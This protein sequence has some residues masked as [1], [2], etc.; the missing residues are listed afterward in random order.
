MDVS[1]DPT[2]NRRYTYGL[3]RWLSP[4]PLAGEVAKP[5]SLNRYAYVGNNPTSLIDPLGLMYCDANSAVLDDEGNT[6]GYTDCV[7]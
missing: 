7:G 3:G 5:Q 1:A 6:V 4:D 2:P